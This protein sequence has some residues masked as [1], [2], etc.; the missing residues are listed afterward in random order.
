MEYT[1]LFIER[2]DKYLNTFVTL[3]ASV[4]EMVIEPKNQSIK[5]D[6]FIE[7]KK[8]CIKL[9]DETND[10]KKSDFS[11]IG[12]EI[13]EEINKRNLEEQASLYAQLMDLIKELKKKFNHLTNE[14]F[15]EYTIDFATDLE[16]KISA[17]QYIIGQ[18]FQFLNLHE[19]FNKR[20][21]VNKGIVIPLDP[22]D[23]IDPAIITAFLEKEKHVIRENGQWDGSVIRLA[24]FCELLYEKKY[25]T[26]KPN[27]K[28][29]RPVTFI[30]SFAKARYGID[31]SIQL[32]S[33][34]KNERV[35]HKNKKKDGKSPLKNLFE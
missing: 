18:R 11:K 23:C 4:E 33:A 1:Y 32:K 20:N 19:Y 10:Y 12:F 35:E 3:I 9:R 22:L 17:T 5:R 16:K 29:D 34:K 27:N 30:N 21:K 6:D 31:I 2:L 15:N 28:K 25:F 13:T 8:D 7:W 14:A 26:E 24:A